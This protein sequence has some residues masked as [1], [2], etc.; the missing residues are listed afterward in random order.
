MKFIG[1]TNELKRINDLISKEGEYNILIYGR[2]RIGK[3]FLIKKALENYNGIVI[4][5]QCKN[6][7]IQDTVQ[8]LSE[9]IT[10][11][12]QLPYLIHFN[13]IDDIFKFLFTNNNNIVFVLD[14]YS[15]L[16]N[17]IE[18][19]NSI[20]QYY[21]DMYKDTSNVKLILSGSQVDIMKNMNAYDNPL[22]GRFN[23]IIEL[24]E[25]DYLESSLYYPNFSNEDKLML[26]SVFGG[27]PLYNSLID[28][29]K[30]VKENILE[31]MVKENSIVEFNISNLMNL[32]LSKINYCNDVL[33]AIACGVKKNDDL[34]TKSHISSSSLLNPV[35]TKLLKLN[36]IKKITPINDLNNK[37][38]TMYLIN[39]NALRFYYKYIYKFD[40]Q[41]S[42]LSPEQ[43]Y[44]EYI[45][46]DFE[47]FL[48]PN[49]FE[50]VTKQYLTIKNKRNE[51]NPP[52]SLIG[53]YWYD[54]AKTK[55][56]VQFDVVTYDKLGYI[57]YEVKYTD[58]LLNKHIVNEEIC[59]LG[60]F[61][62][63]YHN[64]GFVSKTGFINVSSDY[65]LITLNDIYSK[66]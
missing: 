56:N 26:Y 49:V 16:I 62:L 19:L 20:V 38:K 30:S 40:N 47:Q 10:L 43:F 9:L 52:F 64:L 60:K 36:L 61:N 21:I 63:N 33:T 14:E 28:D 57:F 17:K 44:D 15:Y 37:K 8:E 3:S 32:E 55:T 51:I 58:S 7:N 5:Y 22:Y 42:N 1:R 53:T 12:F 6:I 50:D 54:D 34:V 29:K 23:D 35:L 2:R 46:N 18:G 11:K 31:L 65:N 13:S 59:Q 25:H 27:E 66:K 4:H 24:K 39:N 41:R 45:K 48:I